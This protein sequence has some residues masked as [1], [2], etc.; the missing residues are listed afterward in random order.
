M[1]LAILPLV[2]GWLGCFCVMRELAA[3][4]HIHPDW[5]L[6]WVLACI[7]WGILLTFIVEGSSAL[8]SF[9]AASISVAWIGSGAILLGLAAGLA[10]RR[11]ALAPAAIREWRAQ[12]TRHWKNQAPADARLLLFGAVTVIGVL[13]GIA[14]TLPTTNY[15]S[16]TYHMARV[17]HWIDQQSVAYYPT[18]NGR[19]LESGPWAEYSMAN[20]YLLQGND[21][22]V[23]L[24]QWFSMLSSVIATC[25]IARQLL[26][27]WKQAA[28]ASD[29]AIDP[30]VYTRQRI[31]ALTCILVAT[32][33]IGIAESV[34]TQND[35]ATAC[36]L[37]C[38]M[39]MALALFFDPTNLW[40]VLGAG[41]ALALGFLTK[42][43][44]ALF[45]AP[46]VAMLVLFLLV[47]L[48][49]NWLRLRLLL[50]LGISF[51]LING[52]QMQRNY[53]LYGSP[54]GSPGTVQ[55]QRNQS[56]TFSGTMSNVIRNLSLHTAT[57]IEPIT[58]YLHNVVLLAH[59]LTGRALND[60]EITFI[61]EPFHLQEGFR[62]GDSDAN[63][64]YHLLLIFISF[65]F[66]IAANRRLEP[67][68]L[69]YGGIIVASFILFCF[70][71]RWQPWH[72]RFHLVFFILFSP[73]VAIVLVNALPRWIPFAI[74][75]GLMYLAF[76][77]LA[78][79]E[80]RPIN[81]ERNFTQLPREQQYFMESSGLYKPYT[82]TADD[83][84]TSGCKEVG[85]NFRFNDWEY[86]IWMLLRNRG[87][88]GRMYNVG[89]QDASATI[90]T[91]NPVPCAVITTSGKLPDPLAMTL[92]D[93]TQHGPINIYWAESGSEWAQLT[94][95]TQPGTVSVFQNE[96]QLPLSSEPMTMTL[97]TGRPGV[98]ELTSTITSAT[99]ISLT[100][101]ELQMTTSS[102]YIQRRALD[103]H[104]LAFEIPSPGETTIITFALRKPLPE[105][106]EIL[107]NIHWVWKPAAAQWAA[108][109]GI[110]NPNGL[111]FV[112]DD[113]FFWI[114]E[115]STT[116]HI[117]ARSQGNLQLYA[118]FWM[119]P[120]LPNVNTRRL[121]VETET[122]Y[123]KEMTISGGEQ[124]ISVPISLADTNIT[125]TP[126]DKPSV[127]I[128]SANDPRP[129]LI[130]VKGLRAELH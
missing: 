24:V 31:T 64:P 22:L 80:T 9:N 34:T 69:L 23:N 67:K 79:N 26:P 126:M 93:R 45:A 36:W 87:F 1:V 86:P 51:V 105:H 52:P 94:Y 115:G 130:G 25:L 58:R 108:I 3:R 61:Y 56:F 114:G 55:L 15:D 44:M 65:A 41:G 106:A 128:T 90:Q 96:Q 14:I 116:L 18:M 104:L 110:D 10:A 71:L 48:N 21:Q 102:G 112:E 37:V 20:L 35:Y 95:F 77:C 40:Y 107:Q 4:Q 81:V 2:L 28:L 127:D 85:L 88:E 16:M 49:R 113:S 47:R 76:M 68:L 5:R 57:G 89:V 12:I 42:A 54:L 111:E 97:R 78:Y 59:S 8:Y 19:Q 99:G 122:G 46:L 62:S 103:Q 83:I 66:L 121:L 124:M 129:L 118:D 84:I 100:D 109:L 60:Q 11:G 92:P 6:S 33:P 39:C 98:L 17:M 63:N 101:N 30:P 123:H 32:L 38:L 91:N 50:I 7:W 27:G 70:Y 73:F 119:G 74:S 72:S 29:V 120:S 125:L 82:D 117:R 13:A 53:A 75:F 43:T